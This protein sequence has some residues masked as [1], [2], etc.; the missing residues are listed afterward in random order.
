MIKVTWL[1]ALFDKRSPNRLP[2]TWFHSVL[3]SEKTSLLFGDCWGYDAEKKSTKRV[4]SYV[5]LL[6]KHFLCNMMLQGSVF[7]SNINF[8]SAIS[9]IS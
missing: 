9:F 2:N 6:C 3:H 8:K 1:I 5:T 7:L 4:Y